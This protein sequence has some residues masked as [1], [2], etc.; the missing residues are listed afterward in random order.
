MIATQYALTGTTPLAFDDAVERVREELKAEGFGVLCEIDVQ[1]TLKAKLDVD[2]ERYL[3]LG[4]CNPPLADRA[5][6]GRAGHRRPPALQRRRVRARRRDPCLRRR[7]R[8]D[9]LDRRA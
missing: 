6:P 3:I 7:R 2:S 1:A 4:A 8:A 9:A 5:L